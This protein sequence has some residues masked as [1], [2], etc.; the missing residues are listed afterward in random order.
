[1]PGNEPKYMLSAGLYGADAVILDLEDSVHHADKDAARDFFT[2]LTGLYKNWNYAAPDTPDFEG[3]QTQMAEL[4]DQFRVGAGAASAE[5]A[6]AE[7]E[8]QSVGEL[9]DQ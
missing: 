4:A 1:M 3:Y 7:A 5:A 8:S 6:P 2:R 9:A